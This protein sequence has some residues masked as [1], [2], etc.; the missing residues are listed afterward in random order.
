MYFVVGVDGQE[1]G[2]RNL[3]SPLPRALRM[4]TDIFLQSCVTHGVLGVPYSANTSVSDEMHPIA[5]NLPHFFPLLSSVAVA[6][7]A[8]AATRSP[9]RNSTGQR[10][11]SAR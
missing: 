3:S 5:K 11:P 6:T 4:T 1:Q 7:A 2:G 9:A 10:D 8:A